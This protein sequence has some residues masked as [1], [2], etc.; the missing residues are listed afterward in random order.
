M[1]LFQHYNYNNECG[2]YENSKNNN[3]NALM[4]MAALTYSMEL[5]HVPYWDQDVALITKSVKNPCVVLPR[6]QMFALECIRNNDV[7]RLDKA[8]KDTILTTETVIGARKGLTLLHGAVL[9]NKPDVVNYLLS[10]GAKLHYDLSVYPDTLN[11]AYDK[12][13]SLEI[14]LLFTQA[15]LGALQ[16]D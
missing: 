13:A 10:K 2:L 3:D 6:R 4:S 12:G 5:G 16:L 9:A 8:I 15:Y 11:Y 1:S 14:R 7:G